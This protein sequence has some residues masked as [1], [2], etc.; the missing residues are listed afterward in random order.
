VF[1]LQYLHNTSPNVTTVVVLLQ[2]LHSTS[3]DVTVVVLQYL[4]DTSADEGNV[5]VLHT[6]TLLQQM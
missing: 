3:A 6:C 4:H 2:Y 1:V 5:F